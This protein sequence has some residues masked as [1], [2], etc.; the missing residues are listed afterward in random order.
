MKSTLELLQD[1]PGELKSK[2]YLDLMASRG[3]AAP[4]PPPPTFKPPQHKAISEMEASSP[5]G[6]D[7]VAML[8]LPQT[9]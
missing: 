9:A 7:A 5:I 2:A 6:E 8:S 1:N 4:P 3:V